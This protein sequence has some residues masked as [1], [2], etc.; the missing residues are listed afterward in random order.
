MN[1]LRCV[2]CMKASSDSFTYYLVKPHASPVKQALFLALFTDE[3][4][5]TQSGQET[6]P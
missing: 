5:K 3:E 2:A 4:I 1:G 6:C